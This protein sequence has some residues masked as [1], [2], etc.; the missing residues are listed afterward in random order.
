M[1]TSIVKKMIWLVVACL[2]FAGVSAFQPNLNNIR[3]EA[4]LTFEEPLQGIPPLLVMTTTVLGSFRGIIADIL[5]MRTISLKEQGKYFEHMQLSDWICKLQPRF[6]SVWA[7]RAWD[8]AYNISVELPT[9]RERWRWVYNSIKLLR[10]EGI[11]YN[12]NSPELYKELA[13]IFYHK[14]GGNLD[15]RHWYYKQMLFEQ[16]NEIIGEPKFELELLARA[17]KETEELL[18][19]EEVNSL[20]KE[21]QTIGV[22]LID[23]FFELLKEDDSIPA[24]A[25]ELFRQKGDDPGMK[26]VEAYCRARRLRTEWKLEPEDMLALTRAFGPLDW[27]FPATHALYWIKKGLKHAPEESSINYDRIAYFAMQDIFYKGKINLIEYEGKKIYLTSPDYRF[28]DSLES[29]FQ[30]NIEFYKESRSFQ[31]IESAYNNFLDNL[32]WVAYFS[33]Q[34]E[35][36]AKYYR[37]KSPDTPV[38]PQALRDFIQTRVKDNIASGSRDDVLRTIEVLLEQAWHSYS[39]GDDTNASFH[40]KQALL[41]YE[42]Y[43]QGYEERERTALLPFKLVKQDVLD[44]ILN[45]QSLLIPFPEILIE[46]LKRRLAADAT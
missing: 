35:K 38:S 4:K 19:D 44:K 24:E 21:F 39:M 12:P 33:G 8:M 20:V 28:I 46:N 22:N 6:P 9:S 36:A 17:P 15:D 29:L 16:I 1:K 10:D 13:W 37:K 40:E 25:H 41:I 18:L 43:N 32:I 23:S 30:K 42:S 14:I 34:T 27:R 31:S 45:K 5:W 26:R 11:K 3:R 7:F 2:F